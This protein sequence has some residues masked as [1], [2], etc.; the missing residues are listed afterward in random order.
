MAPRNLQQQRRRRQRKMSKNTTTTTTE[1]SEEDRRR[2]QG[3]GEYDG[4]DSGLTMGPVDWQQQRSVD[5]TCYRVANSNTV[6][7][8]SYH[9][10]VL[11]LFSLDSFFLFTAKILSILQSCG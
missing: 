8:L 9:C 2:V 3:I 1:V 6:S 4:G 11:I 5:F 7:S 10:L